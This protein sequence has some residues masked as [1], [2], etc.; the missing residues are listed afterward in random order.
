M[1]D[2]GGPP[3]LTPTRQP[4]PRR[5]LPSVSPPPSKRRKSAP[6]RILKQGDGGEG[7]DTNS[8]QGVEDDP[9]HLAVKQE[10]GEDID[11]RQVCSIIFVCM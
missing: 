7:S 4:P 6:V 2:K 11:T 9:E 1:T 10:Q 5:V 3:P 8:N